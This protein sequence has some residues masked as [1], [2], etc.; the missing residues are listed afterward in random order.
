INHRFDLL[1]GIA[2]FLLVL[3]VVQVVYGTEVREAIDHLNDEGVSR[4]DWISRLGSSYDIHRILAYV[5]L[6]MT[7]LLFFL[8]KNKFSSLTLQSKYAWIVLILIG[9]QMMSGITLARFNVPAV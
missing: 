4:R 1:K 3:T 9:I 5:S 6:G 2:I 8:V 7:V